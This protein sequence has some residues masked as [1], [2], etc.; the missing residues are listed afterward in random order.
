MTTRGPDRSTTGYHQGELL[1][2]QRAGV[3]A[4][5][6]RIDRMLD[7]ADLSGGIV[8]FLGE[9]T[10][11]FLTA[12][13]EAGTLW[14]SP[15]NG[16]AGFLQ[17]S[18]PTRLRIATGPAAGDPLAGLPAGQSVGL[19]TIDLA[20]RR[21]FRINGH[22]ADVGRTG[23]TVDVEQAYGNCPQ[24]IQQRHL[25]VPATRQEAFTPTGPWPVS[26][27]LEPEDVVQIREA[28]TFFLGTTHPKRGGDA[29][30]RGGP[31]GFVR[32]EDDR[33]LWWPDYPGN[34]M[35][36]SLG[37]IAVDPVA[38]LLFVDFA[39][40]R[41]LHL[42]GRADLDIAPPGGAGDDGGTGRRIRFHAAAR[43]TG[44]VLDLRAEHTNSYAGNPPIR[45]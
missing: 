21:R 34:N 16:R 1:V 41:T 44:A 18:S 45:D 23:L 12:R 39:T 29:S 22:L 28:D 40:G 30:H 10:L 25:S 2:Q 5:A 31:S 35:F 26:D 8:G 6:R 36:N 20:K 17:V 19:V 13:D 38:A 37:N 32:V 33:T 9:R 3:R 7:P 24:F 4:E 42:T 15:L 27:H 14:I 43:T 11:A